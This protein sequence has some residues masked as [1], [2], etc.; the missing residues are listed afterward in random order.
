MPS[1][2]ETPP[3]PVLSVVVCTYNR[4]HLLATAIDALLNQVQGTP[5]YEVIVVDN[6]SSDGTRDVVERFGSGMVRYAF[7]GR[8]GLSVARNHGVALAG[9]DLVAF[10]DDD[11][12]VEAHWVQS[13]VQ[14][15]SEHA[16]VD[17]VGG[18]VEPVWEEAPPAWLR[19]A[20]PAPLALLDFGEDA[21]RVT[22]ERPIALIG[23]N[24]AIR[25]RAFDRIGGFSP[26][27]QRVCDSIG[28]TEDYEFQMRLIGQ[29]GGALYDPRIVVRAAVAPE[30]LKKQYHRAWHAGHGHFYALMHEPTFERSRIGTF[31]GVPAHVYR[32]VVCEAAGW[33]ASVLGRRSTAAFAHELRLRFLIGFAAE[34]I[35]GRS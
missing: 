21:F 19:E 22:P 17:M 34:R 8:Q 9:A 25:R 4:A 12:Q 31:L 24:V 10:T 16:D 27:V 20:G 14:A 18:K 7:E 35:F 1:G 11:V 15:F 29:G 2:V 5:P 26:V 23:A 28:S 3:P 32:S 6:N 30:R 33:A 13:I